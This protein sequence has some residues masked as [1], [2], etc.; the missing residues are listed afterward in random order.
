[1]NR[2]PAVPAQHPV[3]TRR[4]AVQAGA[5]GLLG[6]GMNHLAPLRALAAPAALPARARS[7]IYVFLSG[8][9][10][11]LGSFDL[12][13]DAPAEVRGEFRPVATRTPGV[14]ICE[15]LPRLAQR[16]HL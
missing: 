5:I 2:P 8:G 4:N 6:L 9:L 11:Q 14:H 13:P 15:H 10:S 16:S 12:K 1:M 3:F 7:V